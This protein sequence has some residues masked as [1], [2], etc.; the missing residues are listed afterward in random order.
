MCVSSTN[1][2][3]RPGGAGAGN[4]HWAVNPPKSAHFDVSGKVRF[5][6]QILPYFRQDDATLV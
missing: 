5:Q 6:M 3:E 2:P 4:V 1:R